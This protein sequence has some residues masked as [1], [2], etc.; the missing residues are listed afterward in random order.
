MHKSETA[1][2]MVVFLIDKIYTLI[3]TTKSVLFPF[4]LLSMRCFLCLCEACRPNED[5]QALG[6]YRSLVSISA[7]KPHFIPHLSNVLNH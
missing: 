4:H 5:Q 3:M 6:P 7:R 1:V 2:L